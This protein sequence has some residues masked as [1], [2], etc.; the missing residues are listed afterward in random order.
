MLSDDNGRRISPEHKNIFLI[1]FKNIFF[2][3]E[4]EIRICVM[5]FY[6]EHGSYGFWQK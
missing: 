5:P 3:S 4:V 1:V 2:G 6:N